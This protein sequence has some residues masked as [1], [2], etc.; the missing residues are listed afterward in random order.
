MVVRLAG[1]RVGHSANRRRV[2]VRMLP[3][4]VP[5][6]IAIVDQLTMVGASRMLDQKH[7]AAAR[8]LQKQSQQAREDASAPNH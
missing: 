3:G 7:V 1:A 4:H 5:M 8:T 2:H 6:R